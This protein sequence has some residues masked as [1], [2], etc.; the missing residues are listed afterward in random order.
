MADPS[1]VKLDDTHYLYA[2]IDPW[3]GDSLQ[4]I[5][6]RDFENWTTTRLNW[7]TKAACQTPISRSSRVWAPGVT[8]GPNGKYYMYVSVGSEVW[9]GVSEHPLGP[10]KNAREDGGTLVSTDLY[11]EFHMIDAEPFIDDDGQ[12]Y[13]YWGS[14]LKWVNG[15]CFVAKLNEDMA[16]FAEEPRDVTPPNYFEAPIMIKRDG[17]YYLMYSE[18]KCTNATYKVQ[19]SVGDSPYGSWELGANSP[20]LST[21]ADSTTIGPG[22][23]TVF[24]ENGQDYI[25]YHRIFSSDTSALLRQLAIDSLNMDQAGNLLKV[26]PSGVTSFIR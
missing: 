25:L 24:S 8:L 5:Y 9:V 18:G 11:P 3:G 6:S 22:H 15:H 23:H 20:I 16:S 10:W 19:Y 26:Q 2:T 21:S 17:R 14:G 13:L 12:A 7:P 1:I 4:V